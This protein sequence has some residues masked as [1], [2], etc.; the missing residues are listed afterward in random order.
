VHLG[1]EPDGECGRGAQYWQL[2]LGEDFF[3]KRRNYLGITWNDKAKM[4]DALILR[5]HLRD[6]L[7][8]VLLKSIGY[9]GTYQPTTEKLQDLRPLDWVT[10]DT[11]ASKLAYR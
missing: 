1:S 4:W 8:R 2:L 11:P 6:L 9:D 3:P 5:D 10:I 7:L